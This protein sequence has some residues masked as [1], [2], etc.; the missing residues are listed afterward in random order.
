MRAPF[1]NNFDC[2]S[3]SNKHY[4]DDFFKIRDPLRLPETGISEEAI[5]HIGT[6]FSQ[7]PDDFN[8]HRGLERILKGRAQMM[9]VRARR[10]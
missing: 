8:L 10:F 6:C 9:Q 5:A 1:F 2:D 7:V 4:R 3:I